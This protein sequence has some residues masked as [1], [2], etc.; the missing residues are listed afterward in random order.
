MSGQRTGRT[1]K[2]IPDFNNII[3][4][5]FYNV[6]KMYDADPDVVTSSGLLVNR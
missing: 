4:R 3:L 1:A 5:A 6:K 2:K